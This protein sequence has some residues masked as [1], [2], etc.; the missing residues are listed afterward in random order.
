TGRSAA[1][2]PYDAVTKSLVETRPE[3]WVRWLGIDGDGVSVVDG[4]LSTYTLEADRVIRVERIHPQETPGI[5]HLEF[6]S[7]YDALVE[8]RLF[9]YNIAIGNRS[10]ETP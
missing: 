5:I 2:K 4:D 9:L 3:D 10:E 1:G 7:S 6:Q 8:D